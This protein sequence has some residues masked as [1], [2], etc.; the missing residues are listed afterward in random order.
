[1]KKITMAVMAM[2][3]LFPYAMSVS[4]E[5]TPA[6]GAAFLRSLK[7]TYIELFT[8]A[9]CLNPQYDALWHSE[10]AKYIG[11][12]QADAT[13]QQLVG[14]C[15]GTETGEDAVRYYQQNGGMQFCCVFLEGVHTFTFSGNRIAGY[16]ALGKQVFSHKYRF[17]KQDTDGNYLFESEDRQEDAFRYFWFRPDSPAETYHIEFRYGNDS[18]QLGQ[19]MSGKYAYWMAS[20]VR[21]NHPDEWEKSIILFVGENLGSTE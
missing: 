20:G 5:T 10:A 15:R 17:L 2:L 4:A 13:V 9:A 1:M 19:L 18:T 12:A 8:E 6:Q 14:A 7:G 11:E 3:L 21:K 16:D